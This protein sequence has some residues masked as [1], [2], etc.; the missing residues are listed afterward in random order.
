[1]RRTGAKILVAFGL[2]TASW[3]FAGQAAFA[4]EE[5][6][7]TVP[8]Y[9]FSGAFLAARAAEL[10]NDLPNAIEYYKRAL[11]FDPQN[12]RLQQSLLLA[13]ISNGS[14]D[15]A[16]PYARKLKKVAAVERFSRLALAV[17]SFRD[18]QYQE[19]EKWLNIVDE[20]DLDQLITTVM[21]GW[22]EVGEGHATK[23]LKTLSDLQG[24][25]WYDLFINYH[26]ALMAAYADK[27]D[28]AV[29]Y[30]EA[31][32]INVAAGAAAPETYMRAAEAYA[33]YLAT[34]GK[35]DE[36]L[37][38]L[39]NAD[40]FV[41]GRAAIS[42][43]R[44][45]LKAGKKVEPIAAGP[46]DGAS[47]ILLNLAT[48]LGRGG[49][50]DSFVRLYLEY[51]R[52]LRPNSDEVL[53]QL[54]AVAE[55]Q[56]QPEQ[57]ISFY[58]QVPEDSPLKQIANLQIGLNLADL[59]RNKEAIERLKSALAA[60]PDDMRAY[61]ALGSVYASEKD[62]RSA[63]ELYDR[64]VAHIGDPDRADWNIFYQRGIAYERLKE[65][66]KAEPNF[67][68][69]LELYPNQPQVLNYLGYSWVDMGIHLKEGL[70][71]IKTAVELR[72]SDG[73][74]VD[75]LGWAYYKLG[76]YDDAVEELERA[77]SLKPGDPVL[78]DHL[79]DA[80]WRVGRKLEATFQWSHASD[81][82][83]EPELLAEVQRKL[84][85]GLP[86]DDVKMAQ[87]PAGGRTLTD[88]PPAELKAGKDADAEPKPVTY[89]VKD[90]DTLRSIAAD[91]LGNG[92]RAKEIRDL[93]PDLKD[94]ADLQPGTEIK[95]PAAK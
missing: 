65:W 12:E 17:D 85:S 39:D 95:L 58:K 14:F 78:N 34:E 32:L 7:D 45:Q 71:L 42:L 82:D 40:D 55:Q 8:T 24:P 63:A 31:V 44:E 91:K 10:E 90:G 51:A 46:A 37:G 53:T 67:K 33:R 4:R 2:T 48:A 13:L 86:A 21:K 74:I 47:E 16:L 36:A 29:K 64:A 15:E 61:V 19:A 60:D 70:E 3:A 66:E 38:I 84:T 27:H 59:D 79:G 68:K 94:S 72:P 41:R 9:S 56:S 22:A 54:A 89:K 75:S 49:G 87:A 62:F 81:L 80:Y 11:A 52:A 69:A 93:N 28:E 83:P 1:M 57:A 20:S 50:G 6:A 5:G 35:R 23:G 88:E 73:Y 43:L 77:V 25:D 30:F 26:K 76:R 92:D 18:K